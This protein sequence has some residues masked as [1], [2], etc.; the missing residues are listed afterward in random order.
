MT[1]RQAFFVG[2]CAGS[3]LTS[4]YIMR[5]V[6]V[7]A[8]VRAFPATAEQIRLIGNNLDRAVLFVTSE[9]IFAGRVPV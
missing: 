4:I 2:M 5:R 8:N 1:K 6:P 7:T 9:G 3:I